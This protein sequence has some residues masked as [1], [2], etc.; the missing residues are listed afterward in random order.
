MR[1]SIAAAL[2]SVALAVTPVPA[3]AVA[4]LPSDGRTLTSMRDIADGATVSF[5]GEVVS[6][7]LH[8]GQD[9]VWVNVLSSGT[10]VGVW[11]PESLAAD[12]ERF[13]DWHHTGDQVRVVGVLNHACDMHG[14]D[15]DVHASEVDVV[16]RGTERA[17][18]VKPWKAAAG[19]GGLAVTLAGAARY[20]RAARR[21]PA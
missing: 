8:G 15:L 12:I 20:R 16:A 10:A 13:G 7:A 18:P 4:P 17:R 11:M 5:A 14:G 19:L 6:E 21:R 2:L 3:M 1:R 9:S